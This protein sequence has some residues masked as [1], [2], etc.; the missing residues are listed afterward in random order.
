MTPDAPA[1]PAP[2]RRTR[3]LAFAAYLVLAVVATWPL[4]RRLT[5]HVLGLPQPP[6]E[7][8]ARLNLWAMALVLRQ[9]PREP[10]RLFE[11][12]AFY[13]HAH[14]L[15]LSEHLFAPSLMAAPFL[16]ASG[17]I[18]LAYNAVTLLSLA[19]AGLGMFL[20]SRQIGVRT[21]G[22]FTAGLLY[23]FHTWNVNETVRIQIVSNQWFPF[24]LLGLLSYFARS[25]PRAAVLVALAA[26]AQALSCMYWALYLPLM[27]V[28]AALF[29]QWRHRLR[30]RSLL[31]LAAA[32]AVAALVVGLFAI[33]YV[34]TARELGL[35]RPEPVAVGINRYF[36]V[37]PENLLYT[38]WLG[39]AR[40]DQNAAHFLGFAAMALAVL[41]MAMPR[42]HP[43][44]RLRPLLVGMA[45]AGFVLSLG[46][47]IRWG[48][49]ALSPGPYALLRELVPGFRNV[50]YPERL[51]LFVVLGLAPLVGLG[52]DRIRQRLPGA[53][54]FALG[55]VVLLE[56]LAIP[57]PLCPMPPPGRMPSVY[58]W[59]RAQPDVRVVA[60][61]P[62]SFY[63][64]ER[65]DSIPMYFSIAHWKRTVQG[66]T[67]YFPPTQSFVRW[68]LFHFP[69]AES[70]EFLRRFGVDT[71]VVAPQGSAPP[72]WVKPDTRWQVVGPFSEGHVALRLANA[73]AQRFA[74][75]PER[76]ESDL[77]EAGRRHWAVEASAPGAE[78][79]I[80]G[81]PSTW[82]RDSLRQEAG[83]FL[84]V[85]FP[86]PV[87]V[88]RVSLLV[89]TPFQ[90]A[91]EFP[92]RL[93]LL[94]KTEA[95]AWEPMAFDEGASYDRLFASLLHRPR[96]SWL[97]L[98]VQPRSVRG[99]ELQITHTDPFELPWTLPELRV[100]R[101]R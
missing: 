22:A 53:A 29:L 95:G 20:L 96:E 90:H 57:R 37:L 65:A 39:T 17:N 100:Y 84:R 68:R 77:V 61:L 30:W 6:G 63:L 35:E 27:V 32:L 25:S 38:R 48:E 97:D 44:A 5:D 56:H 14:T 13:P 15:A 72:P 71:V 40:R 67:G 80:D 60:G 70:V 78:L 3:L 51:S 42:D 79:A 7:G 64:M 81:D 9:L 46:P 66:Y 92:T 49:R 52:V 10:L 1:P 58:H 99:I 12:N 8:S 11:G 33:P 88:A 47:E 73:D 50:R 26:A 89:K 54:A 59:L 62:G 93:R 94:G 87:E 24:V 31:P 28:A 23:A 2:S 16:L 41:G 76:G 91:A 83:D 55:A 74:P 82:W 18:V 34:R 36:D 19:L 45:A 98:E 75:P 85:R 21:A 86:R 4:G 69:A 101:R 43:A